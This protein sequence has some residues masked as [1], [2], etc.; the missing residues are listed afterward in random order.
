MVHE[1]EVAALLLAALHRRHP[2]RRALQQ[3]PWH[4]HLPRHPP[5][6]RVEVLR[7]VCPQQ[8]LPQPVA[9]AGCAGE[10]EGR[11]DD[12]RREAEALMH[13]GDEEGVA[14]GEDG[15]GEDADDEAAVVPEEEALL[16]KGAAGVLQLH[17]A[18]REA[19]AAAR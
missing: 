13:A 3:P 4:V 6:P 19:A 18:L 5:V 9:L 12:V 7:R 17:A 16:A 14:A 2:R 1:L 8:P 10:L 15:D 11:V